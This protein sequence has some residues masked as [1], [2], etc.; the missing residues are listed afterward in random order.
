MT[1]ELPIPQV[2]GW[3]ALYEKNAR[4]KCIKDAPPMYGFGRELKAGDIVNVAGVCWRGKYEISVAE[5]CAF[6]TLEGYF[7]PLLPT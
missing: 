4:A 2:T 3:Q 5:E 6:Y 1:N 7:E